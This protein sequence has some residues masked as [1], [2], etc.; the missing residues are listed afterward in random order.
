[1]KKLS[2]PAVIAKLSCVALLAWGLVSAVPVLATNGSRAVATKQGFAFPKPTRNRIILFHPDISVSELSTG[3]IDQPKVDWTKSAR[4]QL[5]ASLIAAEKQA[6]NLVIP[7]PEVK[8]DDA[9]LLANYTALYKIVA[10]AALKNNLFRDDPLPGKYDRFDWT[11]GPGAAKLGA[12]AAS[13]DGGGDYGLFISSNDSYR[14]SSRASAEA[15]ADLFG[16]PVPAGEHYGNASL[17]DLHSGDIIWMIVDGEMTG[18]VRTPE[19]A[20]ERISQL[21]HGFPGIPEPVA[22]VAVPTQ[23]KAALKTHAK[24][25]GV[26]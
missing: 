9:K 8:G 24:K 5:Q 25:G 14:S 16:M 22:I 15:T 26:K 1:M 12:L 7:M 13:A 19:G 17:I 3:G 6:G 11:L 18:D 23:T 10:E 4:E 20:K 21:L 2:S